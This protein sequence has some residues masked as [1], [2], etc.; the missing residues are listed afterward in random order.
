[1]QPAYEACGRE[2]G[3]LTTLGC[4]MEVDSAD[5]RSTSARLDR[6]QLCATIF[7][8][9][10]PPHQRPDTTHKH[11]ILMLSAHFKA[12]LLP[13]ALNLLQQLSVTMSPEAKGIV[14]RQQYS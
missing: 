12:V 11:I 2:G 13:K 10:R 5:S 4:W 7:T 14:S 3:L 9:T 8:A 1:M 6:A